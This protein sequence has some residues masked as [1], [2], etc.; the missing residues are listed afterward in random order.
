MAVRPAA[1]TDYMRLA[2]REARRGVGRTSP[3]PPVG[4]VVVTARGTV[5][6]R[7]F[8][9]QAG[10]P[11]AEID[12]LRM[13][14]PASRGA[15]L[16]VTLEPCAHHG[17]TPPCTEAIL[18]AAVRR[19]VIGTRDPNPHVPGQ[20]AER[21]TAAGLEVTTGVLEPACTELIAPFS[22]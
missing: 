2:L 18:A 8:H 15:T 14:G 16:F 3:N 7:G 17:R 22:K 5:V 13:A 10:A 19:V 20:G 9:R 21:L 11:H 1:D 4:A 12:A 6:G